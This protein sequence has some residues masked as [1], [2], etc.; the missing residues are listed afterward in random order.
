MMYKALVGELHI[1]EV[2]TKRLTNEVGTK[3][4]MATEWLIIPVNIQVLE[5]I[6]KPNL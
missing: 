5:W 4:A 1:N 3:I 2:T 6:K